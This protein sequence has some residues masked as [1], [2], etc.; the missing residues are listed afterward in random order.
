[1]RDW[2]VD[3]E[4]MKGVAEGAAKGLEGW[5]GVGSAEEVRKGVLEGIF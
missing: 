2:G 1:M 3:E 4:G 5:E